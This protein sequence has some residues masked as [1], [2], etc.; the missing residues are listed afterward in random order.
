M[1]RAMEKQIYATVSD[2]R[3]AESFP[4]PQQ[5]HLQ[6]T[7]FAQKDAREF[8]Q[9]LVKFATFSSWILEKIELKACPK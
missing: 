2:S 7:N 6:K 1:I 8:T 5:L 4:L 3:A 9:K